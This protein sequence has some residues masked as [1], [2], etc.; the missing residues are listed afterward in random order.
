MHA[1][2]IAKRQFALDRQGSG[3]RLAGGRWNSPGLAVVYAGMTPEIAAMEKLVHTGDILPSDLVLV[4]FDLPDTQNLYRYYE[5]EDLPHGWDAL[6]GSAAAAGIGDKFVVDGNYLGMIVP[7]SVLPEAKNI[8]LNPNH[9]AFSMVEM[10]IV[11][12]FE[13]D[14]RLFN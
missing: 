2:R 12:P 13:F 11:R 14:S 5:I 8:V 4:R 1:W 9:N 6:P 7:S 3:A 10:T